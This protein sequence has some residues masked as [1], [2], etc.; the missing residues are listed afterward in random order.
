M[1]LEMYMRNKLP[2]ETYDPMLVKRPLAVSSDQIPSER[3]D[4][5]TSAS[6][7]QIT[8]VVEEYFGGQ[9]FF[10]TSK[11]KLG[12]GSGRYAKGKECVFVTSTFQKTKNPNENFFLIT[13]KP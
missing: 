7:K 2:G 10:N 5:K 6:E 1:T 11:L 3:F 8:E 4:M 9:G 12:P 13:V